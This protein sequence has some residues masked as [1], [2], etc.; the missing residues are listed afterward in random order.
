MPEMVEELLELV[1]K[2]LGFLVVGG[3]VGEV[4]MP[5][6]IHVT[7]LSGLG[8]S[9]V[10]S[11]QSTECL[12]TSRGSSGG[13]AGQLGLL[14]LMAP[15]LRFADHLDVAQRP[16]PV[17]AGRIEVVDAEGLLEDV[18]LVL[19]AQGGHGLAAWNM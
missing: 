6:A 17:W 2:A 10:V 1:V 12:A 11:H 16:G 7:R 13:P 5:V 19:P 18:S 3:R 14:A 8:R 4:D 9:S 15:A